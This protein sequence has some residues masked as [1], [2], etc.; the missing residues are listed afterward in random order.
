MKDTLNLEFLNKV[1][2][3]SV[4]IQQNNQYCSYNKVD[5]DLDQA[6]IRIYCLQSEYHF[7]VDNPYIHLIEV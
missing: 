5:I 2:T 7:W 1:Y 6:V 3:I 4:T